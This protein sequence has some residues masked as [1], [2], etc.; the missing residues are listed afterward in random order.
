MV[1]DRRP[2][3]AT[4]PDSLCDQFA[5][6]VDRVDPYLGVARLLINEDLIKARIRVARREVDEDR[7][8]RGDR[9]RQSFQ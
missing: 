6:P 7:I 1:R 9:S 2:L 4:K 3:G 5:R 8:P